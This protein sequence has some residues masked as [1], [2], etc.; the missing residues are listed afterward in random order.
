MGKRSPRVDAGGTVTSGNMTW[1]V[2]PDVFLIIRH[3]VEA[4]ITWKSEAIFQEKTGNPIGR[5]TDRGQHDRAIQRRHGGR[6]SHPEAAR[7]WLQF[8][9]SEAGSRPSRPT[10]SNAS[11]RR[12][13]SYR[14]FNTMTRSLL[15]SVTARSFA[16]C[17]V[18]TAVAPLPQAPRTKLSTWPIDSSLSWMRNCGMR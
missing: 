1:T 8:I 17:S 11:S 5:Y 4:G 12:R 9:G 18:V 10:V 15:G 16:T 2:K 14:I 3:L 6:R 7:A 13:S